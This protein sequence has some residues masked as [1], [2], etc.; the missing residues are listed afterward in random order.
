MEIATVDE[1]VHYYGRLRERTL[2]V[3]SCIP[4][5]KIEWSYAE[6][7][8]TFG[9]ILRHI[10]AIERYMWAEVV[11]LRPNRYRGCGIEM[12]NGY[13][14]VL[15]FLNELHG[16]SL[17]LFSQLSE[18]DMQR[19][20]VTPK[21]ASITTWKWLRALCEHEIHHRGQIY[22][23]LGILGISTPPLYGLTS[24]EVAERGEHDSKP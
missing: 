6:G 9:G 14:K 17:D 13:D 20:C 8:F 12:A 10:A 21:G 24:E 19:K 11:H 16:E 23:Y 5:E 3:T 2:R 4:P 18:S 7:K 1:F 22:T 15:D